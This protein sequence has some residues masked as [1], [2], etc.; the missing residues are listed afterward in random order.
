MNLS[1]IKFTESDY[2]YLS[3]YMFVCMYAYNVEWFLLSVFGITVSEIS[4]FFSDYVNNVVQSYIL[5]L[6]Y[7]RD[8]KND[9][10]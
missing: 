6:Q 4:I 5:F 7:E 8:H 10:R 1:N 9:P 2:L 3:V